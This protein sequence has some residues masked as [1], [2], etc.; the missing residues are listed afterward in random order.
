MVIY[1]SHTKMQGQQN[2]KILN[3]V[4]CSFNKLSY[5]KQGSANTYQSVECDPR[6]LILGKPGINL[7]QKRKSL[8]AERNSKPGSPSPQPTAVPAVRQTATLLPIQPV[9]TGSN[10]DSCSLFLTECCFVSICIWFLN[11]PRHN[12]AGF[13]AKL[14]Q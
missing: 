10:A 1:K 3:D 13:R 8:V 14:G 11:S 2:I 7:S 6:L 4:P 12:T 5:V 9:G